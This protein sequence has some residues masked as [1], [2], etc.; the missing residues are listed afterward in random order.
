MARRSSNTF[1]VT[2][3]PVSD[4]CGLT[5]D[6]AAHSIYVQLFMYQFC[7]AA[8]QSKSASQVMSRY[9]ATDAPF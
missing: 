8:N 2:G 6:M 5:G 3:K 4:A 7:V 9:T 1:N